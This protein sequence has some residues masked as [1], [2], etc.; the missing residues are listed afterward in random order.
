LGKVTI[1]LSATFQNYFIFLAT[2]GM[3]AS[4]VPIIIDIQVLP[5]KPD[6]SLQG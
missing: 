5:S 3:A 2:S 4:D 6:L 1:R